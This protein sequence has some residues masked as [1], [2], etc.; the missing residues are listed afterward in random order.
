MKPA[1]CLAAIL[2]ASPFAFAKSDPRPDRILMDFN[3]SSFGDWTTKGEAFGDK[4]VSAADPRVPKNLQ[5]AEGSGFATTA[6]P[7][8]STATGSTG[9][10]T[11]P[12]FVIDR[13]FLNFRIG[14]NHRNSLFVTLMVDGS[15]VRPKVKRP[16]T[17]TGDQLVPWGWDVRDLAG[18]TAR[19]IIDDKSRDVDGSRHLH[20]DDIR[21][22]D[23]PAVPTRSAT[24]KL[25]GTYL[26][27]PIAAAGP[28]TQVIVTVDGVPVA[29][30]DIILPQPGAA[31][32]MW[33]SIW[34][35][36]Y[37]GREA[38]LTFDEAHPGIDLAAGIT[39]SDEV[40]HQ[41][42]LYSEALR[43]QF[44]F[45]P[46]R[47]WLNDPNGM[48]YV[49]GEW[50][51]FYQHN[52]F[53]LTITNQSWGHAVSK[54]LLHWKELP[55]VLPPYVFSKGKS[56]SGSAVIDRQNR[57]GFGSK[58]NPAMV[59][60]YTDT[61]SNT[62]GETDRAECLAY[63]T[64]LGKTFTYYQGNP[65]YS[66]K[67][68]GRDPKVFWYPPSDL[69]QTQGHWV[70][71]TFSTENKK[72]GLRIL[73]SD[74]LKSWSETDWL[75]D[76]HECP[77]LYELPVLDAKGEKTGQTRWVLH[78]GDGKYFVGSFDGRK[79]MPDHH[80]KLQ[81]MV[82]PYYYASQRFN[83]APN[84]RI[85][86][87]GWVRRHF[88]WA[89]MPFS[90]MMSI[91]LELTLRQTPE[92]IRQFANP[93]RELETIRT[94][95]F[96]KENIVVTPAQP[97][98]LPLSGQLFDVEYSFQCP[99]GSELTLELGEERITYPG[100]DALKVLNEKPA[101]SPVTLRVLM[102]RP[103]LEVIA[104]GGSVY[105]GIP[106]KAPGQ[107]AASLRLSAKGGPVNVSKVRASELSSTW[108]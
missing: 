5:G 89:G 46:K 16:L 17:V 100:T 9:S 41:T 55:P 59:A 31:P 25:S 63:S 98:D 14:G 10:L 13:D 66:H 40:P 105:I 52:A 21:L 53:G 106:R 97:L 65:V 99:E 24:T 26:N 77:E 79:F 30:G 72:G 78:G 54:D 68:N 19:I 37:K 22:S 62:T 93:V 18:Q 75:A 27:I 70:M 38:A 23:T 74:D 15:P 8:K 103:V 48:V 6:N 51:L 3:A 92:G 47:G 107:D 96:E 44:H 82:P 12:P 4:P 64:D 28:E 73:V 87:M 1:L 90:Q 20:I 33:A 67:E 102:D 45:S 42:P 43:P 50:H 86:E 36:P 81:T 83:D 7:R 58:E 88:D 91:P 11:S 85:V 95:T 29:Q 2:A 35:E 84:G 39:S 56:Y 57:T 94:K 34:L 108:K 69:E 104:N 61:A 101:N 49:N 80:E 32:D 60:I 76:F 71:V